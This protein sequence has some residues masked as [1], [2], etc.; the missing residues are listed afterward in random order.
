[1]H[2]RDQLRSRLLEQQPDRVCAL[3]ESAYLLAK[4]VLPNTPVYRHDTPPD[5]PC[6]LALGIDILTGLNAQQA[7]Q[8]INKTRLYI[9]PR[10]LLA[11]PS[12]CALDENTFR[13]LG[14]MQF[15]T[16]STDSTRIFHYDLDSYKT[17][18]DWLNTRFWAHPERWKP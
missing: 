5:S 18:P 7:Q 11:V 8:L 12:D 17:V 14:F 13:A 9:A 15:A 6:A 1:M 2:W 3:D 16:D 10:I 4:S